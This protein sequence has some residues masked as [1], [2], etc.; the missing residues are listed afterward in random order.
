MKTIIRIS[1][2]LTILVA[3][4]ASG[5]AFAQTTD[6]LSRLKDEIDRNAELL[7]QAKEFVAQTGSAKARASLQIS[8]ELHQESVR[9][10]GMGPG[11]GNIA[12]AAHMTARARESILQTIAIAKRESKLEESAKKAI[13]RATM[14]LERAR[15]LFQ[16][17]DQA[18]VAPRKLL[19]EAHDHL[20]RANHNMRE[21]LYEVAAR[22]AASSEELSTRAI[23]LIRRDVSD[24]AVVKRE[25]E[26]TDRVLER[27]AEQAGDCSTRRW[28]C[29]GAR[30]PRRRRDGR[31]RL[32]S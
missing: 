5:P 10:F 28:T 32:S 27:L 12:R 22:L 29:S 13:E 17:T 25:L 9:L 14:R 20:Q 16:N 21:H 31:V 19:E 4:A 11:D 2:V 24:A 7:M 15:Q 1:T 8:A 26:R 6:D 23:A 18:A 3:L 30:R